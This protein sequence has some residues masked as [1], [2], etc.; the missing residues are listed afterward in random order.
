M[1]DMPQYVN[2]D[3]NVNVVAGEVF[4]LPPHYTIAD[5]I[6]QGAHGKVCSAINEQTEELVAVKKNSDVF[7]H[8]K[9]RHV[10]GRRTAIVDSVDQDPIDLI[11]PLRVLRELKILSHLSQHPYIVQLKDAILPSSYDEF[12]DLY[13]VTDYM[14]TD[15][16][17][18]LNTK[19]QLQDDH[20]Q[21]ILY[22][23][24]MAV[25][26]AHS[27]DIVHRDIKPYDLITQLTM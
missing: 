7:P 22:Q 10:Y 25:L 4:V 27:A 8:S 26:Y 15:L 11:H 17:S 2:Q 21:Y 5:M 6:G 23:L 3:L 9:M 14:P 16:R 1:R 12:C 24:L 13:M 19:K 18:F 20:I